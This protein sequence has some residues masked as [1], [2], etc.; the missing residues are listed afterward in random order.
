MKKYLFLFAALLAIVA[1]EQKIEILPA[2]NQSETVLVFK[3]DKPQFENT[4]R[5]AWDAD[6]RSIV[7]TS[8]DKIS[9]GY[10]LDGNWMAK[11]SQADVQGDPKVSPK[12]YASEVVTIDSENASIGT[13]TVPSSFEFSSA[14][15]AVFYGVFPSSA[16]GNNLDYAPSLTITIP[17]S[18]TP[19]DNTF[20]PAADLMVGKSGGITLT[21]AL[22][23]DPIDL[24]WDR[25]VAHAD[26][27][28]KNLQVDGDASVNKITLVFNSEAKVVGRF[29]LDVTNGAVTTTD[30]SSNQIDILGNNLSINEGS[31][32]AWAAVLPV[33]FTSVDVT[34]KTDLA[35]YTRSITGISKTF[36]QNARN[37]LA[38]NMAG[39]SRTLN[40]III[41]DGNY[42]IA[43]ESIETYYA[44][45]SSNNANS[46][47][48]DRIELPE[49]F[50]PSSYSASTPY[51]ADN[52]IIWTITNV[53]GGVTINLAGDA[54]SYMQYGNNTLPL[55]NSGAIF[56]VEEG[57]GTYTFTN[58]GRYISMNG[59]YGFGCYSSSTD[60]YVIPA[61]GI[62]SITFETLSKTVSASTTTVEFEYTSS[63]LS[64]TPEVAV[65]ED[66]GSAVI[67]ATVNDAAGKIIVSLNPNST[68]S[69]KTIKLAVSAQGVST[70]TLNITQSKFVSY[71]NKWVLVTNVSEMAIGDKVVIVNTA[72]D[73]ALGTT[74]NNN[75]RNAVD[76]TLDADDNYIVNIN[77]N[78]QQLTLGQTG[79]Y[80]TFYTGSGYL[81][82]ASSSSNYLRTQT[83]NNDNG[84]W[85]I[86][87]DA[88][89]YVASITA[90]GSNTHNE[91]KNNG[92]YFSCYENG[93]TDVKIYK[94]HEDPNAPS[95]S[96]SPITSSDAPAAWEA[97]ND[98][99]K[100]FTV[101]ATNGTWSFDA[102][103]VSSWANVSRNGDVITVVPIVKQAVQDNSGSIV[104]TLTPTNS[105]YS[106]QI[107]TL[108]L[109]QSRFNGASGKTMQ[110]LFHE[111][112][113]NNSGSAR[114]WNDNYSV[115]TGVSDVYSDISS[116]TVTN[117][118]QSKNTI[119]SAN[120]GL[121][122]TTKGT[123]AVLIIGPL[124]VS[125][126]EDMVLKYQWN[127]ASIKG[128][129]STHLYYATSSTGT[130][131]EV[132]GTGN[133]ATTFVER[134]YQLPEAAQVS[135]LYL[136]I[137]WNTSNTSAIIDEVDLSGL[138]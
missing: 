68:S 77:D 54:N 58:N 109:S 4:T 94:F 19:G 53:S 122:Q 35:T 124:N 69:N 129:Y 13:F 132:S 120:S 126:A 74:Q 70:L 47:R 51:S 30:N 11:S 63:F 23:T 104:V 64:N 103:N 67:S 79:N 110:T 85:S 101:T 83:E 80:W 72:G 97:D 41:P 46:Q 17:T 6:S 8:N 95:L 16:L 133:G 88:N 115:K 137:T 55:G 71:S 59:Q 98:D 116:Y 87:I 91:L 24:D 113:G 108:Y 112:F 62:P 114:A 136:K 7:W 36:K 14:G 15:T 52:S 38:I 66:A 45:S 84:Q 118:K 82:A 42:V 92:Q 27:T 127:A 138:Y 99:P 40:S 9:V 25:V 117:A 111:S 49:G 128:T 56:E 10:T 28:F 123:D 1:C 2:N 89:T 100:T 76:V 33:T 31:I 75:N 102:T 65:V 106:E 107:V 78:V 32:E 121:I 34:V 130:Y 73:K 39:A 105:Q 22:P 21:D 29:F 131:T 20:D 12:F 125:D 18:Q 37:T 96:V 134:S 48:R 93:Q 26:I 135:T 90:Q 81:Y 119:G 5:T 3:S 50:N 57:D 43:A 60:L 61:A 86:S 44:I